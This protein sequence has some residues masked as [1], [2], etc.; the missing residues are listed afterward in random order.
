[1]K[2]FFVYMGNGMNSRQFI[3]HIQDVIREHQLLNN[4]NHVLIAVSGGI[5]SVTL[6]NVLW[7]IRESWQLK[8]H[9]IHINHGLRGY[10]ADRD[11]RFVHDLGASLN[12][13]VSAKTVDV[14]AFVKQMHCSLEE[15]A[16]MVRYQCFGEFLTSLQADVVALAHHAD[17]QAETVLD[18]FLRGSGLRGL[19]G[20][21][22]K[23]GHNIRPLLDVTRQDIET[24]AHAEGLKYVTDITNTD[25]RMKRNRIRH[26]LIPLLQREFNPSI[27]SGLNRTATI[28][29]HAHD[30]FVNEAVKSMERCAIQIQKEKIILDIHQFFQYFNIIK[31]Y[32]LY[33]IVNTLAG[34]EIQIPSSLQ[35]RFLKFIEQHHIGTK[36][37]L[38]EGLEILIDHDGLVFHR[39][40]QTISAVPVAMNCWQRIDGESI[41]I[42]VM[43]CNDALHEPKKNKP[44]SIEYLDLDHVHAPL[45]MRTFI[46]GDSFVPLNGM[47]SKTVSDFFTDLKVP[48]HERYHIP[49]LLDQRGIIWIAGYRIA[50][51]VKLTDRTTRVLTLELRK[52]FHD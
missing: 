7:H 44:S 10:D 37:E 52:D 11:E 30:Y 17:D 49:L 29:S 15:G 27:V 46:P 39:P 35:W 40:C 31:I 36:L 48:L 23:N 8:I 28:F 4:G 18:H 21:R 38:P 51:R 41:A 20:M 50:D 33:Y 2:G 9:L 19:A 34:K 47:G 42:R 14:R 24:Y 32:V 13:P 26:T 3:E 5:D 25:E 16:R 22:W 43:V 12:L 45:V 1:M 6:T